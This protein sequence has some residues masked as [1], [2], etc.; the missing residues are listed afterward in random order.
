MM[1]LSD[2]AKTVDTALPSAALTKAK[3]GALE[4]IRSCQHSKGA[5]PWFEGGIL[6]PWDHTEALM[7]LSL[8]GYTDEA[9]LALQWLETSQSEDGYWF[10]NYRDNRPTNNKKIETN[11]VAYPATGLWHHYLLTQDKQSLKKFYPMVEKAIN[12]VIAQQSPEGDIQWALCDGEVLPRD[13]LVT[14]CSSILRSLECAIACAEVLNKNT[15]AWLESYQR[16]FNA[17]KNK[18]WR[19]DRTWE[20]KERYSMDWFYP[21]L[22]GIY[23]EAESRLRLKESWNKF[24]QD[25]VGC[26]CVSDEPWMTVAESCELSLALSASGKKQEAIALLNTL[27]KWQ[28]KDGGFWTGYNFRDNT[29]WPREKTTWTAGAFVLAMDA[30]FSLSPASHL[31]TSYSSVQNEGL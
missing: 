23:G 19:F 6:D 27:L 21:V 22:A 9:R 2:N 28:D 13:A 10:A 15:Q 1:N 4:Y 30:A 3:T 25:E 26:R 31:F 5:I 8:G 12:Y 16:L 14:A 24:Y 11:F 17:L 20:S 18:P 29:I 7:A